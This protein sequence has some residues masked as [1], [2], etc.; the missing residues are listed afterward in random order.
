MATI[1]YIPYL[2][3]YA[4]DLTTKCVVQYNLPIAQLSVAYIWQLG[5]GQC[6][7]LNLTIADTS[8]L[9]LFKKKPE[10]LARLENEKVVALHTM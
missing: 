5:V 1:Y 4:D 3:Y 6:N 2:F 10:F 9:I 8:S 7:P